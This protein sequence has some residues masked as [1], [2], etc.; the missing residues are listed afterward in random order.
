MD[1]HGTMHFTVTGEF[2]T[3]HARDIMLSDYPS[4]AYQFVTRNLIGEE[5]DRAAKGILEGTHK[6]VGS[7]V[8]SLEEDD[9]SDYQRDVRDLYA[10]RCRIEGRWWRPVAEV[11]QPHAGAM[12]RI[13]SQIDSEET[14]MGAALLSRGWA[15]RCAQHYATA[16]ERV[17]KVIHACP[18]RQNYTGR[19]ESVRA[20]AQELR[21]RWIIW[22]PCGEPPFW[23]DR[24]QSPADALAQFLQVG[25]TLKIRGKQ[26]DAHTLLIEMKSRM[27]VEEK[28]ELD[29]DI[30]DLREAEREL[31]LKAIGEKVREQAGD[32]TFILDAGLG[33]EIV[34]PR[35]PFIHWAL[36]R[37]SLRHLA[38]EW[39][40]VSPVGLKMMNDSPHHSDWM[41]GAGLDLDTDY[42][43]GS[44]IARAA[45][46]AIWHLQQELGGFDAAVLVDNGPV[47]GE[48]GKEVLV[49]PDLGPAHAEA[50]MQPQVKAI[51]TEAGGALAHLCV[52]GREQGWTIMRVEDARRIYLDGATLEITPDE[53][54]I[55]IQME[56]A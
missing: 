13:L 40:T 47:R 10:G 45:V 12:R 43:P 53:G 26:A 39:A 18:K 11:T 36:Y 2:F 22:E 48:V 56:Y 23:W 34:V 8:L 16:E 54:R 1:E 21:A 27:T 32:D 44:P 7:N 35:A 49:L 24:H 52:I 25:R 5:G 6:L 46:E 14:R 37:T 51:V 50:A 42:A 30:D 28:E 41:L 4:D 15:E 17:I 31:A 9:A 33:E 55:T 29:S 3:E 19:Y 38:P 20:A